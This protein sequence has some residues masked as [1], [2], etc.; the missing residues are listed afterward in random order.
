MENYINEAITEYS[1]IESISPKLGFIKGAL[2]I[3]KIDINMNN[4]IKKGT[5]FFLKIKSKYSDNFYHYYLI[6]NEHV[7]E[8]D[9]IKE[10]QIKFI[11]Y[12]H[13]EEI[14]KEFTINTSETFIKEYNTNENVDI[15]IIQI[16]QNEIPSQYFIEPDYNFYNNILLDEQFLKV[17]DSTKTDIII[18]QFPLGLEQSYSKGNIFEINDSNIF[19]TNSTENG[20]SG[21]PIM[22]IGSEKV[23]GIHS[24]KYENQKNQ[25]FLLDIVINDKERIE[26][27]D[28]YEE[29]N[30]HLK[31]YDAIIKEKTLNGRKY[32]KDNYIISLDNKNSIFCFNIE[33]I[34]NKKLFQYYININNF[35]DKIIKDGNKLSYK[36][37]IE[38]IF[39]KVDTNIY[40]SKIEEKDEILIFNI[41]GNDFNLYH[42]KQ[43]GITIIYKDDNN[44][45][46]KLFGSQFIKRNKDNFKLIINNQEE[47]LCEFYP[48]K[49][50]ENMLIILLKQ[51]K[52]ITDISEMFENCNQ[53]YEISY[54]SN[55]IP[56]K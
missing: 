35:Y 43:E 36:Q 40:Q 9:L 12:Y 53:L 41:F 26:K 19:Y 6:T 7:I 46:I 39:K 37:K 49:R 33:N 23:I 5:G 8:K 54:I 32:V 50:G 3:F 2:S 20:S 28:F 45:Q 14:Y 25:G 15:T 38:E 1:K 13:F 24:R 47:E 31:D 11:I 21:S 18:H 29:K 34:N 4:K 51:I 30:K 42:K 56:I 17:K 48:K 27:C 55:L 52:P 22:L 10:R 44:N 16:K